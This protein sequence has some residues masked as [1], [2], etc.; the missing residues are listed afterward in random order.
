LVPAGSKAFFLRKEK[1]MK[2]ILW[3]MF[4][5]V[6]TGGLIFA[7]GTNQQGSSPSAGST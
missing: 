4:V 6:V 2:K 3:V 1:G 7:G 5:F